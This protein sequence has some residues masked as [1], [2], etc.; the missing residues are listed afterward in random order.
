MNNCRA[1]SKLRDLAPGGAPVSVAAQAEQLASYTMHSERA[2]H[3]AV[4]GTPGSEQDA[5]PP[6]PAETSEENVEF[7]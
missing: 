7:F 2:V 6:S 4:Y 5:P 3:H 1:V